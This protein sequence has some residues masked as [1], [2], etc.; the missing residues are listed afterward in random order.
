MGSCPPHGQAVPGH[1]VVRGGIT[2][3]AGRRR[4]PWPSATTWQPI[5][6]ARWP[7]RR[8]TARP[9]GLYAFLCNELR[10]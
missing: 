7:R 4:G 2:I 3:R 8:P 1:R 5:S 6:T 10:W 9:R